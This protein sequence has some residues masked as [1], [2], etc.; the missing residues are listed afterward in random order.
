M[1]ETAARLGIALQLDRLSQ[2]EAALAHLRAVVAARPRAPSGAMARAH[3][4]LGD[5]LHHLGQR[6]EAAA[7]YRAAIAAAGPNDPPGITAS[8]RAALRAMGR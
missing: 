1:A 2:P 4:Q 3:L 5:A 7:A 6:G 8:A